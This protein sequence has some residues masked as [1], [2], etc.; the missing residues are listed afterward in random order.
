MGVSICSGLAYEQF[1]TEKK[2]DAIRDE[3][4][5]AYAAAVKSGS[6]CSPQKEQIRSC[7]SSTPQP[8]SQKG[9]L[10]KSAGYS[11]QDL[12][13]L[14]EEAVV[15]SFGCGNPLAFRGVKEGDVVVD[16][17]AGA[18]IDVILAAQKVGQSGKAIGIDM[19]DDMIARA[20]ENI[21]KAG[22]HNAEIRKGIIEELPIDDQSVDWVISNCVI[23]LS[24]EKSRVFSEVHR[25]LR[26]GGKMSVSDVMVRDLPEWVRKNQALY[27]SCVAGAIDEDEYLEGLRKAGMVNVKVEDRILYEDVQLRS[28]LLSEVSDVQGSKEFLKA[29]ENQD[30][31]E[32]AVQELRGKIWSAKVYA[33]KP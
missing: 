4:S 29:Q 15:N 8:G 24:P 20:R 30:F 9:V 27:C 5:K 28:M 2:T 17:G 23:N 3:V 7:C 11:A 33:E 14:P 12:A 19:T 21:R 16:L 25:V 31:L 26:S 10:A 13:S 1:M 6:C 32:N 18:G 22:L